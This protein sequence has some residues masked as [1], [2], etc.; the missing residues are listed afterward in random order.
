M[1]DVKRSQLGNATISPTTTQ[2][3]QPL[4]TTAS[5]VF[6]SIG[7][8]TRYG[9][10]VL[11]QYGE[12]HGQS[13]NTFVDGHDNSE[14]FQL[15]VADSDAPPP[16]PETTYY[17][18]LYVFDINRLA[19]ASNVVRARTRKIRAKLSRDGSVPM[20][21]PSTG[22]MAGGTAVTIKGTR[23]HEGMR[24]RLGDKILENLV[25]VDTETATG[26]TPEVFNKSI[27]SVHID[28]SI[29]SDTGLVDMA[30]DVFKYSE[31]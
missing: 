3:N 23:F 2:F 20:I 7:S 6:A 25:I 28:L 11:T 17:Y 26:T 8:S 29:T 4:P 9:R 21:T 16:E 1:E 30:K 19:S 18:R 12:A 31:T 14:E 24:V 22:P 10:S 15:T 5:L 13:V 27:L